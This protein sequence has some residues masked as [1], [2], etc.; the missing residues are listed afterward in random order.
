MSQPSWQPGPTYGAQPVDAPDPY[1]PQPAYSPPGFYGQP[2]VQPS[3][4]QPTS[5]SERGP[6][7]GY[8]QQP[9]FGSTPGYGEQPG[10]SGAYPGWQQPPVIAHGGWSRALFVLAILNV[11]LGAFALIGA[12]ATLATATTTE[13]VVVGL[14]I[15]VAGLIQVV[16]CSFLIW[17]TATGRRRADAGDPRRLRA[18]GILA[19]VFGAIALADTVV[20]LADAISS[21]STPVGGLGGLLILVIGIQLIRLTKPR[22]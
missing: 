16:V 9:G 4:G 17:L 8:V 5:A 7:P 12:F 2:A 14:Y 11:V 1:A 13:V 18:A 20:A 19:T 22:Y 6:Q 21:G 3:P 10:Y 15:L